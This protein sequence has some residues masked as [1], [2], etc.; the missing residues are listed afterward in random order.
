M[1][2]FAPGIATSAR[3]RTATPPPRSA[4]ATRRPRGGESLAI[5][6]GVVVVASLIVLPLV[7]VFY[8]ALRAGAA[9]FVSVFGD[10]Y[11]RSAILLTVQTAAIVVV[12]NTLFG[13]LAA[14]TIAKYRFPGKALL[15]SAIDLPLS[16]SPVVAGL[17]I[18]LSLGAHSPVG[19]WLVAHGIR[20]A[21]APPGIAIA[22][23]FV[24]FPYVA[25]E[26]S[27]YLSEQGR[28]LEEAALALGGSVW[29]TLWRVT[30]PGARWA[31]LNGILL[32][33]ARAI[34]EFGAVSVISG[35]I[36]GLTDTVPLHIEILYNEDAF[37]AAFAL[38]ATLAS[39]TIGLS[40]VRSWIEHA[41]KTPT[42]SV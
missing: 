6:I 35:R 23:I 26:L 24:T 15:T 40:L 25:R 28:D 22:T 31:L 5:A 29:Q 21:F 4:P 7:S 32:C 41:T 17:A 19:A 38:A 2:A 36:R 13:V 14:W 18:L 42:E 12:F 20:I 33:N 3:P 34:G 27:S 9:G 39:V 37:V 1:E 10:P 11:A 8:E 30:L 16:V